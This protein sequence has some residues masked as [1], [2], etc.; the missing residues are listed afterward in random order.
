[1][2]HRSSLNDERGEQHFLDRRV[3]LL[4]L[5]SGIENAVDLLLD[6][7]GEEF[8]AVLAHQLRSLLAR[9]E[10]GDVVAQLG[11]VQ[12]E[13]IA[14]LWVVYLYRKNQLQKL[15][16]AFRNE[17][18]GERIKGH[19]DRCRFPIGLF[20]LGGS[21]L[22]RRDF[23]VVHLV[24]GSRLQQ[25]EG[26]HPT[27]AEHEHDRSDDDD[28]QLLAALRWYRFRAGN[29]WL[30]ILDHSAL[31][32]L[33]VAVVSKYAAGATFD[34]ARRQLLRENIDHRAPAL[35]GGGLSQ[36][37]A[38]RIDAKYSLIGQLAGWV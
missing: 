14:R 17:I 20:L 32:S 2:A 36:E 8:L 31:L 11:A 26:G 25:H 24:L 16:A 18:D 9:Q 4:P 23:A 12:L 30:G 10:Q 15:V 1:M 28:E 19:I 29:R 37:S 5:A 3:T 21:C 33:D 13:L 7:P 27:Y 22:F 34:G 35:R 38:R 6:L